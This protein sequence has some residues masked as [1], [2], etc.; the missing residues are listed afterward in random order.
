MPLILHRH[1]Y[2]VEF[3]RDAVGKVFR[4]GILGIV[5]CVCFIA[6]WSSP[7]HTT[8]IQKHRKEIDQKC[9]LGR[10]D[11]MYA[12]QR[13]R[14]G[15]VDKCLVYGVVG[16]LCTG[17]GKA[18][19]WCRVNLSALMFCNSGGV[20]DSIS[21]Y[22]VLFSS[23]RDSSRSFYIY[24]ACRMIKYQTPSSFHYLKEFPDCFLRSCLCIPSGAARRCPRTGR[25]RSWTCW[26]W[27]ARE[28]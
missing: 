13:G 8:Y 16:K 24:K 19:H 26:R 28:S 9:S 6:V 15:T 10:S 3:C 23:I 18:F 14:C 2:H 7:R 5:K 1:L 11:K 21:V 25:R 12:A 22:S 20:P 4:F 27:L 17:C